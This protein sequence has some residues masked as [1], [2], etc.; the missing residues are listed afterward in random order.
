ME[1]GPEEKAGP[2]ACA[3]GDAE[4][5]SAFDAHLVGRAPTPAPRLPSAEEERVR[6]AAWP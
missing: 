2:C 4:S 5:L 3:D 1:P 6:E